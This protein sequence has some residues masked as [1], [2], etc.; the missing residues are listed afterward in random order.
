MKTAII[1]NNFRVAVGVNVLFL[2]YFAIS[3]YV[4]FY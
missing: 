1:A 4:S 3:I 2:T